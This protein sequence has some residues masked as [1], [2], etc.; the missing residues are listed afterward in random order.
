M[1]VTVRQKPKGSGV[2]WVFINHQGKR[3]SKKIGTDEDVAN[4]VANTIDAK[5]KLG[6]YEFEKPKSQAPKLKEY[7]SIWLEDYIKPLR[8]QSTY[9]RYSDIL[10]R[11]VFPALGKK[12][13]DKIKRGE[14]RNLLLNL[15]KKG[16]SRSMLCLVR[17]VI[18]GPSPDVARN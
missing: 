7:A 12:P 8:R 3:A 17:D 14:I 9:E 1:G 15:Y 10:N 11:Y 2:Y 16:L 13:I 4:Q 5:L 18:S 6:Q